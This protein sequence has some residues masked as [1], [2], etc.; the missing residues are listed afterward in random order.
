MGL[1]DVLTR[2]ARDREFAKQLIANPSQF[3]DEYQLTDE[4]LASIG[5]AGEAVATAPS[6]ARYEDSTD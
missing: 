2:A 5:G 1:T 4:Q 6:T 3:K